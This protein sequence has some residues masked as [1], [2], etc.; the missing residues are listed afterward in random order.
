MNTDIWLLFWFLL[1]AHLFSDWFVQP[2]WIAHGKGKFPLLMCVH[3]LWWVGALSIPLFFYAKLHVWKLVFLFVGH[4]IIDIWKA[5]KYD[6]LV[7]EEK[8][9]L[10]KF[11]NYVYVD[12]ALHIAQMAVVVIL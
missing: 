12:Q 7:V 5:K 2:E 10:E 3:C 8:M 11:V 6:K 4:W 1:V 9:P